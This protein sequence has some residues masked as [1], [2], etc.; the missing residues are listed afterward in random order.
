VKKTSGSTL[1]PDSGRRNVYLLLF[2]SWCHYNTKNSRYYFYKNK[3]VNFD[4]SSWSFI[5]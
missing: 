1:H 3:R 5:L 2:H 4:R